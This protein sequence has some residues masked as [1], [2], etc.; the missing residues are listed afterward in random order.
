VRPCSKAFLDYWLSWWAA[1]QFGWVSNKYLAV[2][3]SI[4]IFNGRG[5]H[6]STS[7]LNLSRF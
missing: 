3:F 6:S 5:L 2:Y 7:Q 4:F 1:D